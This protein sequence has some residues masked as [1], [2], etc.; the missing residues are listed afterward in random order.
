MSSCSFT[1]PNICIN[2]SSRLSSH[3]DT[4][5][6]DGA[7][8]ELKV[9]PSKPFV[10]QVFKSVVDPYAGKMNIFKVIQGKVSS[11]DTVWNATQGK[12][13]R[14]GTIYVVCGKKQESVASLSAGDIGAFSKLANTF[15]NDTLC[16][17]SAKITVDPIKFPSPVISLAVTFRPRW[18]FSIW[19][20][21]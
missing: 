19:C 9:D 6:I 10:A 2:C 21:I 17:Q 20:F 18:D 8:V 1:P 4:S 13:E 15:T 5:L 12:P 14:I 3:F 7:A 16:D 11:G